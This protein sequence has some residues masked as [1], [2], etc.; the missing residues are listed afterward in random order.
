MASLTRKTL[1]KRRARAYK[2]GRRRK[3]VLSKKS[4][5]SYTELFAG[6]GQP[7]DTNAKS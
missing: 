4:T 2:M 3:N 7:T 5:L 1:A 6:C